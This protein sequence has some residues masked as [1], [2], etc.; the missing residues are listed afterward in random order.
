VREYSVQPDTLVTDAADITGHVSQLIPNNIKQLVSDPNLE[1]LFLMNTDEYSSEGNDM[2]VYKFFWQGNEKVQS[3]W[4]KWDFWFKPIGGAA[5][6]GSL[7]MLGTESVDEVK[8]TV[9]T[10]VNLSDRP[11]VL[12]TDEQDEFKSTRP[13]IDRLTLVSEDSQRDTDY[14]I[15]LEVTFEQYQYFDLDGTIPVLVDRHSGELLEVSS[16]YTE[17]GVYY[18]VFDKLAAPTDLG[19][20]ECLRLGSYGL[21]G[22]LVFPYSADPTDLGYLEC[23]VLGSYTLGVCD[24]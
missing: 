21:G 16:R 14:T 10:R 17:G 22:C 8:R 9:M 11:E 6:D 7:Y 12:L 13:T 18:F 23:F 24:E 5:F 20:L 4:Q 1:F 19:D 3:S 15:V 2:F